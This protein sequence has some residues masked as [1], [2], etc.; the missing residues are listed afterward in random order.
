MW[1]LH[2]LDV[3]TMYFYGHDNIYL[4]TGTPGDGTALPPN[5]HA[6]SWNGAL[7][8]THYTFNPQMIFIN[9]YELIRMSQQALSTNPANTGNTDALTFAFRYYQFINSRAGFAFHNEYSIVWQRNINVN[10]TTLLPIGLTSSSVM[11]GFDFAF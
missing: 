1:Y 9:R 8:E 5:A 4:G 3:T 7:I 2:K 10:P 6:P 11:F